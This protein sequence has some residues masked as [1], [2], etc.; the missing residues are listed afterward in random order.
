RLARLMEIVG[1]GEPPV[2]A[3]GAYYWDRYGRQYL[4]FLSAF[5]A[6]NLGHNPA[7]VEQAVARVRDLPNLSDGLSPLAGVLAHNLAAI[8]PGGLTRVH[9]ANSGTEVV[10]AAIKFARAATRRPRVVACHESFHGRSIGALSCTD[11][12]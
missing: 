10:D 11:H 8:A 2:R 12:V 5:G 9:L 4:D 1:A 3:S 6:L 7:A